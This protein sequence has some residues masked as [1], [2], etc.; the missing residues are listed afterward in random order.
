[1]TPPYL[2]LHCEEFAW[3]HVSPHAPVRSY[4]KPSRA[5]PFHPSPRISNLRSS[6][7]NSSSSLS[8]APDSAAG[9]FSVALVVARKPQ[10]SE[11]RRSGAPPLAGSPPC[12]VR[13][14]LSWTQLKPDNFR[15]NPKMKVL[16]ELLRISAP[17]LKPVIPNLR[18]E[19][20]S[21]QQRPPDLFTC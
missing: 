21:F 2:I 7:R 12:S 9:L 6:I 15:C 10:I 3:P 4:F 18:S 16:S 11:L 8:R 1:L 14:F 17:N 5:A 19:T 20:R 13:T